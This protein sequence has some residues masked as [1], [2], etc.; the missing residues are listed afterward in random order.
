MKPILNWLF[1]VFIRIRGG[2]YDQ[3]KWYQCLKNGNLLSNDT[4]KRFFNEK[5]GG[6]CYGLCRDSKHRIRYSHGGDHLG[7]STFMQSFFEDDLCIIILANNDF[8]NQYR[9]GNQIADIIFMSKAAVLP[10]KRPE[11]AIDEELA[12]KYEGVYLNKKIEL[13]RNNGV[14][15]FV[16]FN[17][18]LHIEIYPFGNHKF[19]RKRGDQFEPYTL[20]E[21]DDG[22]FAFFGFKKIT[23]QS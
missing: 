11:I 14:W 2:F 15:E 3:I 20:T 16:R 13:Y 19:G 9:L 22:T 4:Y 21:C 12:R 6:Y 17:G 1:S 18:N 10:Q 5:L 23:G 7:I 8:V